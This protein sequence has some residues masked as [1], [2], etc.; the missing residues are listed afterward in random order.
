MAIRS[1]P[2]LYET[3]LGQDRFFASNQSWRTDPE[4]KDARG[5]ASPSRGALPDVS[6][7]GEHR[8]PGTRW[9]ILPE[10]MDGHPP[11]STSPLDR[12]RAAV[13]RQSGFIAS[14]GCLSVSLRRT[15]A[16]IRS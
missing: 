12:L 7:S 2:R 11:D 16:G 1:S 10:G 3:A 15:G 13:A 5:V 14:A 9:G 8:G 4:L 6:R